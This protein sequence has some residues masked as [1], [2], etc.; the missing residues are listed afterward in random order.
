MN[1]KP[2][3]LVLLPLLISL[4]ACN[5]D[6][7]HSVAAPQLEVVAATGQQWTG[8]AVSSKGNVFVNFPNWTEDANIS[9]AKII[10]GEPVAYPSLD[11]NNR[12]RAEAFQAVQ[13]VVIDKADRLWVL[14]TN[15]PRFGGVQDPGPSLYQ[16]DLTNNKMVNR[17]TFPQEAY[18]SQSYYND[19]RIDVQ[20]EIAYITDSGEGAIIVL[21]LKTGKARRLLK[22]HASVKH[23]TDYLMCNGN[24][25][26]GAVDADGLAL[27]PDGKW[28]YYIALS[29]HTLYRAPT[30]A[31]RDTT[32]S[33][34]ELAQAVEKV[35]AVPATDGMLFDA[36]GNLWM[37]GLENNAINQ[38]ANDGM[39]YRVVQDSSLK[40]VDSFAKAANGE[41]YFTTSQI[42]LP[43]N[44]RTAYKVMKLA[45]ETL[46]KKP[47]DKILIAI[48]SHGTLGENSGDSTGYYLSEVSHAYYVFK[49]AGFQ[50]AF[51]SPKG[52]QSPVDGYNLKDPYNKR[53]VKDSIAQGAIN[54]ALPAS[55]VNVNDY[56]AIYFAGGHGTMWDFPDNSAFQRASREIYETGGVVA[57]VCHGPAGLVN[58]KLSDNTYLVNNRTVA[59]FTNE[60]EQISGLT[61]TVPFL[62]QSKLEKRGATVLA[63]APYQQQVVVDGRLVTG[64]NP[65]SAKKAAEKI[66]ALLTR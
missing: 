65:A 29:S 13:S 12:D 30:D 33:A 27:T 7:T 6:E 64:Q 61:E 56:R 3:A 58:I 2:I 28:L 41:I 40:W 19:V 35:M 54:N 25:W 36:K 34:T 15:N 23:E 60:E 49:E 62:L 42:H 9:V 38:L 10:D 1:L 14:D 11:W 26:Q 18:T 52:G 21:D 51:A 5:T 8:V 57:A 32:L 22:N 47:L 50:V 4:Q 37:G 55:E 20:Q 59:A 66:V 31:L 45:P 44:E 53:F 17:Y 39:L 46:E 16:F 43:P 48:T 63:G 24:K